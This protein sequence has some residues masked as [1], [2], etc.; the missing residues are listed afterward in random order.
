M[1]LNLKNPRTLQAVDELARLTGESK[2]DA[3]A[4]AVEARLAALLL[5]KDAARAA[6]PSTEDRLRELTADSAARF[7]RAGVG[8]GGSPDLTAELYDANGLPA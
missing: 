6:E 3:I 5:A 8:V 4:S 2:T 7:A 1:A